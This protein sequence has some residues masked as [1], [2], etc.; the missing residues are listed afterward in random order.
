MATVLAVFSTKPIRYISL[1]YWVMIMAKALLFLMGH[2]AQEKT[3]GRRFA[4]Y[5]LLINTM[6]MKSE[7]TPNL[8]LARSGET[9]SVSIAE[10]RVCRIG[11][12]NPLDSD[13]QAS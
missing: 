7:P 2:M 5:A 1:L 11:V 9:R 12:S 6:L 13:T 3:C 4:I 10:L 8:N